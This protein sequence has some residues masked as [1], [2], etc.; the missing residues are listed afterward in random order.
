MRVKEI[1]I[2]VM[3]NLVGYSRIKIIGEEASYR[4]PRGD[5]D[6]AV[7][8]ECHCGCDACKESDDG[9]YGTYSNN[10][11]NQWLVLIEE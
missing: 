2:D 9:I 8:L 7:E 10:N 4:E 3:T 6:D 1:L 5:G 11:K